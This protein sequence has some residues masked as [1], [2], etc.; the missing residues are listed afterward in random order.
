[1]PAATHM[2]AAL[3]GGAAR[4]A[5]SS[6]IHLLHLTVQLD[7][8]AWLPSVCSHATKAA[9]QLPFLLTIRAYAKAALQTGGYW[10]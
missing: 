3:Q 8:T 1:M 5:L 7:L 6:H 9:D 10:R 4:P 2:W